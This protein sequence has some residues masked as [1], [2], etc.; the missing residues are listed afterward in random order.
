MSLD[1]ESTEHH[2]GLCVCLEGLAGVPAAFEQDALLDQHE[3]PGRQKLREHPRT[4]QG[5]VT[6]AESARRGASVTG[7]L[8]QHAHSIDLGTAVTFRHGSR[9]SVLE[10]PLGALQLSVVDLEARAP[11]QRE[12]PEGLGHV[13]GQRE[14]VQRVEL[15]PLLVTLPE[16]AQDPLATRVCSELPLGVVR[17]ERQGPRIET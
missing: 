13:R 1:P 12:G 7:D 5:L 4:R 15:P 3:P 8:C 2:G 9:P 14:A 11:V 6:Q 10:V 17:E 16:E